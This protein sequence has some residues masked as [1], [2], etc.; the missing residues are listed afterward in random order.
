MNRFMFLYSLALARCLREGA[1]VRLQSRGDPITGSIAGQP[2]HLADLISR[3]ARQQLPAAE[4]IAQCA[5]TWLS[6]G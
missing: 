3:M 6:A 4:S 2:Q 5:R 1:I